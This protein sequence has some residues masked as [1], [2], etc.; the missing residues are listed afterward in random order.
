[1]YE[2]NH[3]SNYVTKSP[4]LKPPNRYSIIASEAGLLGVDD[5]ELSLA[6]A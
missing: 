5:F 2:A 4:G 6:A 3:H 1:M